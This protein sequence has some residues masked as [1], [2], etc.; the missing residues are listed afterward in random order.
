MATVNPIAVLPLD[1]SGTAAEN[2]ITGEIHVIGVNKII[3]PKYGCFHKKDL[4]LNILPSGDALTEDQYMVMD[5][6]LEATQVTSDAEIWNTIIIT[7]TAIAGNVSVDYQALG[8]PWSKHND[9]LIA[10]LESRQVNTGTL[11]WPDVT[12]VPKKFNPSKHLHLLEHV[13]GMEYIVDSL[14]RVEEAIKVGSGPVYEAFLSNI[15]AKLNLIATRAHDAVDE[16]LL[17][18]FNSF[19]SFSNAEGIGLGLLINAGLM[20]RDTA[21]A[22][23]NPGFDSRAITNEQYVAISSLDAFYEAFYDVVVSRS[24]NLD[25]DQGIDADPSRPSLLL[26]TNGA[27]ICIPSKLRAVAEGRVIDDY[28]YPEGVSENDEFICSKINGNEFNYGGVYMMFNKSNLDTYIGVLINDG[29]ATSIEWNKMLFTGELDEFHNLIEAH[30]ADTKNPHEV[31]KDD[32]ELGKVENLPVITEDEIINNKSARKY[33][34]LDT[35]MYYM[36]KYLTNAKPP[37]LPG[38]TLDPNAKTMDQCHILF[39][40]CK[41]PEPLPENWPSKGQLIK[42][43]CDQTDKMAR[44]TDGGGG[45]YDEVFELNASDCGYIVHPK[46]GELVSSYCGS[47]AGNSEVATDK[48]GRYG[49]GD[50]TTYEELIRANDPDCGYVAPEPKDKEGTVIAVYCSGVKGEQKTRYADGLGGFTELV[51]GVNVAQCGGTGSSTGTPPSGTPGP[52]PPGTPAPAGT[53]ISTTCVGTTKRT[54]YADGNGGTYTIDAEND[55]SCANQPTP[56]PVAGNE[57]FTGSAFMAWVTN[58]TSE[59][60]TLGEDRPIYIGGYGFVPGTDYYFRVEVREDNSSQWIPIR[61]DYVRVNVENDLFY[62]WGSVPFIVRGRVW[63]R[64]LVSVKGSEGFQYNSGQRKM[65]IS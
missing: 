20:S 34:T 33:I 26:L 8:G 51:T 53:V 23:A 56:D 3:V 42:T 60:G 37:P 19:K 52:T 39:A 44:Y 54:T 6:Y 2:K 50:G 25:L 32:I 11:D 41:K 22:I 48:I 9:K 65:D 57:R 17:E 59:T 1:Y 61:E 15:D 4:V 29:C 28:I 62:P 46:R 12:D 31:N 13:Y 18:R 30:I 64:L 55:E 49:N 47:I 16:M 58:P 21:K 5:L 27:V 24:T 14:K 38:E 35:I 43:Y 45:F 10:W 7:D 36:R 40:P 63:F